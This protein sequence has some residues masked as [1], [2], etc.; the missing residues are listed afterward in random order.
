MCADRQAA[1]SACSGR[2][3]CVCHEARASAILSKAVKAQA[4][5]GR[6]SEREPDQGGEDAVTAGCRNGIRGLVIDPYNELDHQRP[7]H[8]NETEYVSQMLTK[9]KRF[10]QHNDVHVWFVAHSAPA[11]GL[12]RGAA[13]PV[14]HQR[15]RALH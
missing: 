5:G 15:Q 10:A 8:M 2:K 13:Q 9:V 1:G 11:A 7:A 3:H 12:A 6:V 4:G 14:R